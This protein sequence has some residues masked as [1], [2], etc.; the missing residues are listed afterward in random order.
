MGDVESVN[1]LFVDCR[2]TKEVI[3]GLG[4]ALQRVITWNEPT[5]KHNMVKW[6]GNEKQL[7]Y[8]PLLMTWQL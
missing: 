4:I 2:F 8:L 1:H 6:T 7:M 3:V 5:Y